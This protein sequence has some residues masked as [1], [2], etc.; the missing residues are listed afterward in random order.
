MQWARELPGRLVFADDRSDS[1]DVAWLWVV[2]QPWPGWQV[3]VVTALPT[4][5]GPPGVP[6]DWEPA[7]LR[8]FPEGID[9]PVRHERVV[10]EPRAALAALRDRDLLVVGPRGRGLRKALHLG[11]VSESLLHDP[12]MPLLIARRGVAARRVMVCADGSPGCN[13]AVAALLAMPWLGQAYVS[14]L[15]VPEQRLDAE[16]ANRQCALTLEGAA[17]SVISQVLTPDRLQVAYHPQEMLLEAAEVWQ[18]DLMVLGHRG[19]SGLAA[20][21]AGSIANSLARRA[22]CSVLVARG[23]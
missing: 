10:G 2:S 15:T 8:R 22:P 17:R 9:V 11:S 20:L 1:A 12:P 18:A 5:A 14:V 3:E 7:H 4:G 23:S 16:Q 6:T 19:L 13:A 21:T